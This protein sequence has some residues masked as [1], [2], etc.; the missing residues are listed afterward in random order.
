MSDRLLLD[1]HI[2]LW[3]DA[4]GKPMPK[5]GVTIEDER[6][7]VS[8]YFDAEPPKD[9]GLEITLNLNVET[10]DV[11]FEFSDLPVPEMPKDE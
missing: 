5:V 8:I 7:V 9:F 4:E 10:L 2:V 1:T 6:N 11:P 3:L